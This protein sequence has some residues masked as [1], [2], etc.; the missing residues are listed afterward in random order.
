M[1]NNIILWLS[2]FFKT[3]CDKIDKE[4]LFEDDSSSDD[5]FLMNL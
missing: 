4:K 5:Y 3:P 2:Y 1:I